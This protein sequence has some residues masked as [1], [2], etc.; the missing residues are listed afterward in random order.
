MCCED[1]IY[2]RNKKCEKKDILIKQIK[3]CEERISQKVIAG[4]FLKIRPRIFKKGLK[5]FGKTRLG[6]CEEV[7]RIYSDLYKV[8]VAPYEIHKA[9]YQHKS[10]V[11][12]HKAWKDYE[13]R[14]DN[15][16]KKARY[17][18][19]EKGDDSKIL[20]EILE[21]NE[22]KELSRIIKVSYKKIKENMEEVR[23]HYL[24]TKKENI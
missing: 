17:K 22:I 4:I 18:P 16:I 3:T 12:I 8:N 11:K 21:G 7:A 1:C 14:R 20:E 9:T 23:N 13:K 19:E 2:I 5:I 15:A 6:T 10:C 24:G